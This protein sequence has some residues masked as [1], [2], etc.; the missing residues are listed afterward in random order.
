V[1]V[2]NVRGLPANDPSVIYC[3]QPC[4]RWRKSPLRN[5]FKEGIDGS[6]TEVIRKFS[7]HLLAKLQSGD[8]AITAAFDALTEDSVLGCWCKPE[9]CHCDVIVE[10]WQNRK[11]DTDAP[12]A[13]K[14]KR[15]GE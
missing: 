15:K 14:R 10:V 13:K 7:L 2:V 3:G 5:P 1:K 11:R 6:R 9:P 4:G 8:P 12:A